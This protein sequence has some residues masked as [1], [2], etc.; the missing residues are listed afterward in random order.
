MCHCRNVAGHHHDS[1]FNRSTVTSGHTG[2]LCVINIHPT[3]MS[4][5]IFMV[6]RVQ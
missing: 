4:G 6:K 3:I 1:D 5:I 2:V